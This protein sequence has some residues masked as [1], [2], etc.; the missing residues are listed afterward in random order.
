GVPAQELPHHLLLALG[1]V[2]VFDP[3]VR[4]SRRRS[5]LRVLGTRDQATRPGN[6]LARVERLDEV[7]IRAEEQPADAVSGGRSL[8]REQDNRELLPES[9]AQELAREVGRPVPVVEIEDYGI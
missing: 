6:H 3:A 4:I 1:E 9:L 7:V 2:E 5:R 8:P